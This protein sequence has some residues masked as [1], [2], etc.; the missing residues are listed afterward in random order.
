MG[1]FID[2]LSG[3]YISAEDSGLTVDDLKLMGGQTEHV[4]GIYGKYHINSEPADGNPAPSTAYGT[5]LTNTESH[6]PTKN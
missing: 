3:K 2:S 4:S 6:F 5:L 1:K